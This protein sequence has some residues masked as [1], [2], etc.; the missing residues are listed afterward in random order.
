MRLIGMR[1]NRV[2]R[3]NHSPRMIKLFAFFL[4][5]YLVV[6]FGFWLCGLVYG[7]LF[8]RPAVYFPARLAA[9]M[10]IVGLAGS[11]I[12]GIGGV[13]FATVVM[14]RAF[15]RREDYRPVP[16]RVAGVVISTGVLGLTLLS[17]YWLAW[18]WLD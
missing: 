12:G 3:P 9:A 1:D 4:V 11:L 17:T 5:I 16:V 8:R 15:A 13:V 2:Q 14:D 6:F 18:E 7:A 10:G